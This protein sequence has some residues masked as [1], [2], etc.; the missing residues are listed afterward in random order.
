LSTHRTPHSPLKQAMPRRGKS[1]CP[2]GT[3]VLLLVIVSAAVIE[4]RGY[5]HRRHDKASKWVNK[6]RS[7][8][9]LQTTGTKGAACPPLRHPAPSFR[10][11]G[12][13]AVTGS[14]CRAGKGGLGCCGVGVGV[15][16]FGFL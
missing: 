9:V 15:G 16:P 12:F 7:P 3:I 1:L 10:C 4:A 5:R 14:P 11:G 8:S 6:V 2:A 13:G